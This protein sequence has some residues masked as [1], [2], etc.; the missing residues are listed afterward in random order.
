MTEVGRVGP[1]VEG[2]N[3]RP[4]ALGTLLLVSDSVYWS[5]T[6]DLLMW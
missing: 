6:V 2:Y 5:F 1:T 3:H 4:D